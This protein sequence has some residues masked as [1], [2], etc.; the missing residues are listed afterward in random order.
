LLPQKLILP[1]GSIGSFFPRQQ[2]VPLPIPPSQPGQFEVFVA[3]LPNAEFDSQCR[4]GIVPAIV[5]GQQTVASLYQ[6]IDFYAGSGDFVDAVKRKGNSDIVFMVSASTSPLFHYGNLEYLNSTGF[7]S[8]SFFR[9]VESITF[10]IQN[11]QIQI[12]MSIK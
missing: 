2:Q 1:F 10:S 4:N 9:R 3:P 8:H 5:G 6:M 11:L 12:G 7:A